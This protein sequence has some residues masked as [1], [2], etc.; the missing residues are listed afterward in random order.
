MSKKKINKIKKL[1]RKE[2]L[3][4]EEMWVSEFKVDEIDPWT[5]AFIFKVTEDML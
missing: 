3:K 5:G 2:R 4:E 1:E